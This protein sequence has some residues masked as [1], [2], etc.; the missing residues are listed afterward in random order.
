MIVAQKHASDSS[1]I[2]IN[3]LNNIVNDPEFK[4]KI[5]ANTTIGE[6]AFLGIPLIGIPSLLRN[7]GGSDVSNSNSLEGLSET[8][9]AM[10]II[11]MK[12]LFLLSKSHI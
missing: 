4:F 11:R 3:K 9:G 10:V 12:V 8:N 6:K 1:I 2:D 5:R 7:S